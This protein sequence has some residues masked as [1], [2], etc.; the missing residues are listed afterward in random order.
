MSATAMDVDDPVEGTEDSGS[1]AVPLANKSK[2][3]KKRFEVKKVIENSKKIKR[4][5]EYCFPSHYFYKRT[6]QECN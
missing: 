5:E 3:G 2:E 6:N 4:A 1:P